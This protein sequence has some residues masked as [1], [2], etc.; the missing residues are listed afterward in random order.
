MRVQQTLISAQ[1][2]NRV[3]AA[4]IGAVGGFSYV[5]L[6]FRPVWGNYLF[7]AGDLGFHTRYAFSAAKSIAD[8]Q[9]PIMFSNDGTRALQPSFLYYS[10]AFLMLCGVWQNLI[11]VSAYKAILISVIVFSAIGACSIYGVLRELGCAR[12]P[13]SIASVSLL[14]CPYFLTNIFARTALAE[15]AAFCIVPLLWLTAIRLWKSATLK[16]FAFVALT[17]TI[18]LLTH[19][20]FI[21]WAF[22][23][24]ATFCLLC[25]GATNSVRPMVLFVAAFAVAFAV[26]APYWLN[27]LL[28]LPHLDITQRD[29]S[30]YYTAVGSGF[31]NDFFD[32]HASGISIMYAGLNADLSPLFPFPYSHPMAASTPRL[33]LQVGIFLSVAMLFGLFVRERTCRSLLAVTIGSMIIACSIFHLVPFWRFVPTPLVV[34]QFPYRLLLFTCVFGA[35]LAGICID[36][37]WQRQNFLAVGTLVLALPISIA[38]FYTPAKRTVIHS[39]MMEMMDF[40][41]HD[42]WERGNAP[43]IAPTKAETIL[44]SSW[45]GNCLKGSI[46]SSGGIV[47]LPILYSRLLTIEVGKKAT[48]IFDSN[49]NAATRVQPG[50]WSISACRVEKIPPVLAPLL[51][52]LLMTMVVIVSI[53]PESVSRASARL[54]ASLRRGLA[55]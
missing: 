51:I 7:D 22:L 25:F 46:S 54:C 21:V 8:L 29:I 14:F 52:V 9:L 12:V 35:A 55:L 45:P 26:A 28:S 10:P 36:R 17:A 37:F 42:Y 5:A 39:S 50:D 4:L 32:G 23:F 16:S 30:P 19:K 24:V 13:A 33:Q 20:I 18:L 15:V 6:Y 43:P 47:E 11:H 3:A 31:H 27:S 2:D 48:E 34:I 1:R 53:P 41:Q 44:S 40:L 38:V 49:K